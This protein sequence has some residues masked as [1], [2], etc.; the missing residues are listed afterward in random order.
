VR[1][2]R[3]QTGFTLLELIIVLFIVG[4]AS[5]VVVFSAGRLHDRTVFN[6]EARRIFHTAKRARE[7]SLIERREMKLRIDA[8]AGRYWID[9]GD[10]KARFSHTVRQGYVLT[11]EEVVFFSKGNSSGGFIKINDGK[12][13]GYSIE[14]DPVLGTPSIKRL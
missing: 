10:E 4:L 12:G 11:G 8:E 6:E 7:L 2:A 3:A 14:V 9:G 5:S 1:G 13:K